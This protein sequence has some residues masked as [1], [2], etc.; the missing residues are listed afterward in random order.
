MVPKSM[1]YTPFKK[2][3]GSLD[4]GQALASLDMWQGWCKKGRGPWWGAQGGRGVAPVSMQPNRL[5]RAR[6]PGSKEMV[7]TTR[8]HWPG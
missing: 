4:N 6:G 8:A 7:A 1:F 2:P 5:A 3:N